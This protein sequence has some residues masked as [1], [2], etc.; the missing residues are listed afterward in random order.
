[1]KITKLLFTTIVITLLCLVSNAQRKQPNIIIVFVDD[2]GYGDLSCYG[3]PTIRTP[4]LDRMAAEGMRFTQFYVGANVCSP[5]RSALLTGRLPL[6]NGMTGENTP[7]LFPYSSG[8]FPASEIT[9]A[10]ALKTKG[11]TTGI[12]GK[13]HLGHLPQHL[14]ANHGFD[15]YYGIPYSNDMLHTRNKSYPPLPLYKDSKLIGEN[16][17]QSVITKAYTQE[18]ISFIKKNKTKPFFLYYANNFPHEPLFVSEDFK[19]KS[20]RGLYGDVVEELDWSVGQVLKT[21]KEQK[22]DKSTL[23]FFTSDNGPSVALQHKYAGGSAGLL[24]EGKKTTYEGGMRVPAI[25]WWPGKIPPN[26]I[27]EA[28][29]TAMDLMPTIINLAK[30]E[31][32]QD[33]VL[34]GVDIMPV[35]TGISDKVSEMVYYYNKTTLHAIRKGDWKAHFYILPSSA[36]SSEVGKKQEQP[37]L[38]N[39]NQDPSERF[40]VG[41]DHPEIIQDLRQEYEKHTKSFNP[42]P[43]QFDKV[44]NRKE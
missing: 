3:H 42:M 5:S 44:I 26:K 10:E 16:P 32:P 7:V 37:L 24:Y 14:P 17:D 6:R 41:K 28:I 27:S 22:L 43:L 40:D 15:Y 39:L 18:A 19:G 38:Y 9:V 33:R 4:N 2:L 25:A 35:L 30:I 23:V 8:G 20:K 34:D 11:Y 12:I 36:K 13:W 21:L 1:M 29:V 31:F